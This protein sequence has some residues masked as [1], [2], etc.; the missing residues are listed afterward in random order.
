M[1]MVFAYVLLLLLLCSAQLVVVDTTKMMASANP[2][3][4]ILVTSDNQQA[5][6]NNQEDN[7]QIWH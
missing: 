1:L 7:M 6:C 5:V 4:W 3:A 2:G